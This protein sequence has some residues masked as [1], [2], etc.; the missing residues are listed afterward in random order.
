MITKQGKEENE[1]PFVKKERPELP[2]TV[3]ELTE[4]CRA[5]QEENDKLN[6]KLR[7]TTTQ[8]ISR[9]GYLVMAPS[10]YN[11]KIAKISFT[12]GKAFVPSN[13]PNINGLLCEL[14]N[15][16]CSV[17]SIEN[18]IEGNIVEEKP[19]TYAEVVA[20]KTKI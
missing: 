5:L 16:G 19:M 6:Q 13:Y 8:D 11:G 15:L 9:A 1:M 12:D 2:A 20:E 4:L 14:K 3:E 7:R 17:E 18:H 10:P